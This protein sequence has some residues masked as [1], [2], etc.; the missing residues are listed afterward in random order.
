VTFAS[1]SART[2]GSSPFQ[3]FAGARSLLPIVYFSSNTNIATVSGN[4]VTIKGAGFTK[5]TAYQPGDETWNPA[6]PVSQILVVNGNAQ[7]ISFS[8]LGSRRYGSAVFAPKVSASSKLPVTFSSS[9]PTVAIITNGMIL[10]T[11]VGQ[12][13][14]TATQ[15]GQGGYLAA[16]PVTQSLSILPGL[17]SVI[18]PPVGKYAYGF[19]PIV[20]NA[21]SS[22]GLPVSYTSQ[23]TN[24][25]VVSGNLLTMK[26]AGTV[27]VIASQSGNSLWAA[28]YSPAQIVTITKSQQSIAF[29]SP[30]V[31][32]FSSA[33]IL[34]LS[35]TASSG[36][37]ITYKSTNTKV[38]AV[39]GSSAV[40][41]GR[42]T[43]TLTAS[44]KGNANYSAANPVSV[45]VT[46]Q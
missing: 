34:P 24:V 29:T 14:I 3:L 12:A 10:P 45:T 18:F 33:G 4:I 39:S 40:I 2:Y 5:I 31:L 36:L 23:N 19:E 9:D 1:L 22:A 30:G 11:G 13:L 35:G 20:L 26:G 6:P 8:S 27:K 28:A 41:K 38:L 46:V 7:K 16:A 32:S 44:Q 15:S 17:Q 42:G 21:T 43:T 37:P 25:A